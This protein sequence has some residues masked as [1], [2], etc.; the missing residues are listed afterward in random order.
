MKTKI[1]I[2]LCFLLFTTSCDKTP[3]NG[4]KQ[5][6]Y[7]ETFIDVYKDE[8]D[9]IVIKK[10]DLTNDVVFLNY[11]VGGVTIQLIAIKFNDTY[12]LLFNTCA[13][14]SPSKKAYF[15]GTGQKLICQNCG[16]GFTLEEA[17]KDLD[18][19]HPIKVQ[20]IEETKDVIIVNKDIVEAQIG[21]F[22]NW[23]GPTS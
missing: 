19:C 10:A 6:T 21:N 9:K 22:T 17:I 15:V 13:A 8:K 12:Y 16:Y 1:F 11:K 18:G 23:A 20:N 7:N 5:L 4:E 3:D 2:I 14:C